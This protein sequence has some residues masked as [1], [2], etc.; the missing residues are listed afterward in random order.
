MFSAA[1]TC[2]SHIEPCLHAQASLVSCSGFGCL[3]IVSTCLL[4]S[5][6]YIPCAMQG[7]Y[8]RGVLLTTTQFHVVC[9]IALLLGEWHMPNIATV[10]SADGLCNI[11]CANNRC[12]LRWAACTSSPLLQAL[13]EMYSWWCH[14]VQP[15]MH[16]LLF[17]R[18][19]AC[20]APSRLL[21]FRCLGDL[22]GLLVI[23]SK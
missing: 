3:C 15:M 4:P 6:E 19:D 9:R 10:Y 20:K 11:D 8:C 18:A 12:L 2:S 17:H 5:P 1:W 23:C 14:T 21:I 13:P 7:L 16:A 22:P